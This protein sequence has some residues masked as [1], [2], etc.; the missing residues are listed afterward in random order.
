MPLRAAQSMWGVLAAV[1]LVW[2]L[3]LFLRRTRS[4]AM[5]RGCIRCS[6]SSDPERDAKVRGILYT[7]RSERFSKY[8][9]T[10]YLWVCP[11]IL[12]IAAF[13]LWGESRQAADP[14]VVSNMMATVT[15]L[16][17]ALAVSV[18][19]TWT[20]SDRVIQ[21]V[22]ATIYLVMAVPPSF[23]SSATSHRFMLCISF[24]SQTFLSQVYPDRR[25]SWALNTLCLAWRLATMAVTPALRGD[26]LVGNLAIYVLACVYNVGI[27]HSALATME[28]EC[29]ALF[30]EREAQSSSSCLES[31]LNIMTDAVV[32]LKP[33]LS[34]WQPSQQ[35]VSMLLRSP[36]LECQKFSD[37]LASDDVERFANFVHSNSADVNAAGSIRVDLVDSM[38]GRVPVRVFHTCTRDPWDQSERHLLGL[39]EDAE[40]ERL[41]SAPVSLREP[42]STLPREAS[43]SSMSD[44]VDGLKYWQT[45]GA[46]VV[47]VRT[48]LNVEV[49]KES[50]SSYGLFAFSEGPS[51]SFSSRFRKARQI[52][53][54][55]E[56]CY[57]LASSGKTDHPRLKY[58]QVEILNPST[59]V[60]YKGK[61]KAKIMSVHEPVDDDTADFWE[62]VDVAF[63]QTELELHIMPLQPPKREKPTK[64]SP[65]NKAGPL[66]RACAT[67]TASL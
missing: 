10:A 42:R 31:L 47:R 56:F 9:D 58:G 49:L 21:L 22:F 32:A 19:W 27:N 28:A 15:A 4:G 61:M 39:L 52:Q 13:C 46:A 35:L 30:G 33:D 53:R 43:D 59:G 55:L 18:I 44:K 29:E 54:W 6:S 36:G 63:R 48:T 3:G 24:L 66:A 38:G 25:L 17:T 26:I 40:P 50:E 64:M 23:T 14:D 51:D 5:I 8:M 65:R 57:V 16:L 67:N 2:L 37:F 1:K 11:A 41:G 7:R 45:E 34:L 20:C 60:K 62:G 12:A